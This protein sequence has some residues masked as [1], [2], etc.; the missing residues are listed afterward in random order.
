MRDEVR[1]RHLAMAASVFVLQSSLLDEIEFVVVATL[2]AMTTSA[3]AATQ[4]HRDDRRRV[5]LAHEHTRRTAAE[6][7]SQ[8]K[9][10]FLVL[11]G[12]ELRQPMGVILTASELLATAPDPRTRER[13]KQPSIARAHPCCV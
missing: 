4:R 13:A 7:S 6:L 11:L 9:T 5:A 10:D 1:E 3:L 8:A 12:H 2:A